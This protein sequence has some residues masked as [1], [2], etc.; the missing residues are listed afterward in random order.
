MNEIWSGVITIATAIIG[1][2]I[3]A[4]LVSN[5]ANTA[6]VIQAATGG[7]AQDLMAAESPVTGN[8]I[9]GGVSLSG[10]AGSVYNV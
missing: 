6:Q 3:L 10:G 2:A 4:V 7:F 1:V 9:L 8:N 5:R